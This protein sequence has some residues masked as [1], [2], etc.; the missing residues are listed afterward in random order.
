MGKRDEVWKHLGIG[1]G[2]LAGA[3]LGLA[4]SVPLGTEPG[5]TAGMVAGAGLVV[6][7]TI[8]SRRNR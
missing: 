8:D 2:T 6:G 7:S 5:L 3:I 4:A 1:L